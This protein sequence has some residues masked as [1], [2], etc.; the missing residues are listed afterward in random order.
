L[1]S[2]GSK[3]TR[4]AAAVLTSALLAACGGGRGA[5]IDGLSALSKKH[6][7]LNIKIAGSNA[8]SKLFR[9]QQKRRTKYVSEATNGLA[10]YAYLSSQSQPAQPTVVADVSA[11]S[12]YCTVATDGSGDR[13][14]GIPVTAPVGTDNFVLDGYDQVPQ[15]G[16][17]QGNELE[18]GTALDV[19]IVQGAAN[20]VNVTFDGV[21][22]SVAILPIWQTSQNDGVA[23]TYSFAVNAYDADNYAIIDVVPFANAL[24]VAIANDP[25]KT[26][27]ITPPASGTDPRFYTLNYNGGL[28]TDAQV[29]ASAAG[30]SQTT[31]MDFTPMITTPNTLTLSISK[32]P[33]GTFTAAMAV[34][35][36]QTPQ[37]YQ[38]YSDLSE[39][40]LNCTVSPTGTN[41]VPWTSG[42]PVTFTVTATAGSGCS[43]AVTGPETNT[44]FALQTIQ[45]TIQP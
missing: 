18:T 22:A 37:S 28:V 33:T 10:I 38:Y 26:L 16:V 42:S 27:S 43:I 12:P 45:V 15:G 7:I 17:V 6:T 40:P 20:Q 29:T 35:S 19:S 30:V 23:H 39:E 32:N 13:V 31:T 4:L 2:P 44:G 11:T 24:S 41:S 36:D 5:S 1:T 8:Q 25:N 3:R 9:L 34:P 14:C 21:I